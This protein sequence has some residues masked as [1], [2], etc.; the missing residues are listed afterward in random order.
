[1][2]GHRKLELSY[3]QIYLTQ[4]L[5]IILDIRTNKLP[6]HFLNML[7]NLVCAFTFFSH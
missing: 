2:A 5:N 7:E 4:M 3:A 1:M 6:T